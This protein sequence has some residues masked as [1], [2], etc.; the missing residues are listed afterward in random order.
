MPV[1]REVVI[2]LSLRFSTSYFFFFALV[3]KLPFGGSEADGFFLYFGDAQ[4][5]KRHLT[6]TPKIETK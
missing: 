5:F 2:V 4:L 6:S 1:S 3:G